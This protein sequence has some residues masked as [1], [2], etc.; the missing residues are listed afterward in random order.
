MPN[1]RVFL[2]ALDFSGCSLHALEHGIEQLRPQPEDV[3]HLVALVHPPPADLRHSLRVDF[4]AH[5][6]EE[7]HM[8]Q[9]KVS[10]KS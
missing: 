2:F 7:R 3:I 1:P 10:R 8:A 6:E 9:L 4:D 5:E